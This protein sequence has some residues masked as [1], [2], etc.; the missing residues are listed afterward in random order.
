MTISKEGEMHSAKETP[1]EQVVN[2]ITECSFK[3]FFFFSL[4]NEMSRVPFSILYLS[5]TYYWSLANISLY[6]HDHMHIV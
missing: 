1:G 6:Y 4:Y 2:V 5:V 3:N